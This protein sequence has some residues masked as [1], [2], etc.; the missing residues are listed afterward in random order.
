MNMKKGI[1]TAAMALL[2][3][4]SALSNVYA[5]PNTK[6]QSEVSV[7]Q[8]AYT[9]KEFKK[10]LKDNISSSDLKKAEGLFNKAI[11]LEDECNEYWDQF[12]KLDLY[13]TSGWNETEM[14]DN[15]PMTFKE[16]SKDFKKDIK[17]D[18]LKKAEGIYNK[19][20]SLE[21]EGKYE[22]ASKK[23]EEIYKLGVYDMASQ[24][25]FEDF[26]KDFKK[27]VKEAEVKKAKAL[28]NQAVAYEK[29]SK[30]DEAYKA[31]EQLDALD[32]FD[33]YTFDDLKEEIK[34][35]AKS[36]DVKKAEDLFNQAIKL[37]KEH[38]I[39]DAEKVWDELYGLD[40]FDY[41]CEIVEA[42]PLSFKEFSKEF[43]KDIKPNILEEAEKLYHTIL[44]VEKEG[45]YDEA[46]KLWDKFWALDVFDDSLYTEED[47][48]YLQHL[49][50][51]EVYEVPTFEEISKDFKK[52]I[53]AD[54]LKKAKDLYEKAVKADEAVEKAWNEL[55]SM[56]I[57]KM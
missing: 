47:S 50:A 26:S 19:M 44:K 21:K 32:L 7:E 42:E 12:Y 1:M 23:I 14:I 48:E 28:Y 51:G 46:T 36:T 18:V 8:M 54:V 4:A 25:S 55:Y 34:K 40:I 15:A 31:W 57:Y 17:K 52:D 13:D 22:E 5:S 56:N 33:S 24:Y 29:D 43:K 16:F 30:L 10:D 38:K 6:A 49:M 41:D 27:D 9:F 20:V 45:N 37:E 2:I 35:D 11:K 39:E 53:K 3:G